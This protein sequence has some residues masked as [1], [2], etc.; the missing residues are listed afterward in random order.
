[1]RAGHHTRPRPLAVQHG[2]RVRN[3]HGIDARSGALGQAGP[4]IADGILLITSGYLGSGSRIPGNVLLT[5]A[6]E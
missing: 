2:R 3:H 5:F 6:P 1:M 4:T